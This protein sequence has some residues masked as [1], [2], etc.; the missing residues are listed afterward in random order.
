MFLD[1]LSICLMGQ[2]LPN[3]HDGL[4]QGMGTAVLGTV[5]RRIQN[6]IQ[7]VQTD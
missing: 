4:V 6:L 7:T 3:S 5:P 2:H 1:H